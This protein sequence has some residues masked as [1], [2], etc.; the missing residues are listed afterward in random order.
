MPGLVPFHF[1]RLTN[2]YPPMNL[3]KYLLSASLLLAFSFSAAGQQVGL[4]MPVLNNLSQGQFASAPVTVTNFNDIVSV[5]F[6]ILWDPAVLSFESVGGF[7]LP[8]LD[9]LDFGLDQ[10]QDGILRFAWV[11]PNGGTTKPDGT[12]MFTITFEVVGAVNAGSNLTFTELPPTTFFEISKLNGVLLDINDVSLDNGFAAVGYMV[13]ANNPA[14]E[15][16]PV[17]VWPNPVNAHS[18]AWFAMRESGVVN[19]QYID[20]KG[21][22]LYSEKYFL[23]SGKHGMEIAFNKMHSVGL[24]CYLVLQAGRQRAVVPLTGF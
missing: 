12:S 15:N 14:W 19:V 20:L 18:K 22:I 10:T 7:N 16:W 3:N 4:S 9:I 23:S 13:S 6:V 11:G 17:A 5:Q 8:D 2:P 24:P 1:D 21:S